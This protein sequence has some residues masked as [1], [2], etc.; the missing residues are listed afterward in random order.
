MEWLRK[1]WAILTV[2]GGIVGTLFVNQYMVILN[3]QNIED[4]KKDHILAAKNYTETLNEM[5]VTIAQVKTT[6]EHLEEDL[7]YVRNAMKR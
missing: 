5:K 6:L 7:T 3:S 2:G 1:Y 4:C